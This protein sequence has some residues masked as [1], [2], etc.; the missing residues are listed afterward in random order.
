MNKKS[1]TTSLISSFAFAIVACT[2]TIPNQTSIFKENFQDLDKEYTFNTKELTESYLKRKLEN[3][4]TT[5]VKGDLLLKEIVYARVK[6]PDLYCD[7]MAENTQMLAD[8]NIVSEISERKLLEP[9]F[10][11]FAECDPF[12]GEFRVN[13]YTTNTQREPSIAMDNDGDF[14]VTWQS[15]YQDGSMY[16]IYAQR[17]NKK[18]IQVGSEFRVNTFTTNFQKNA[19]V[20]MDAD[21]DFVITWNS[22]YK[23][24]DQFLGVNAQRYNSS[25]NPVGSEFRV[26]TRTTNSQYFPDVAMDADGD[27]VIAWQSAAQDGSSGDS[28]Y[29]QRYFSDGT[30]NGGEFR[31][32]TNITSVQSH[33]SVA[34]DSGGDIVITWQSYHTGDYAIYGQRYFSNGGANGGEFRINTF[35]TDRQ[36]NSSV[37]MDNQGDF[38]V[39]WQSKQDNGTGTGNLSAYGIYAQRYNRSGGAVGGE[40]QV[41][42][43]TTNMQSHP[44]VAMDSNGDFVVSWGSY[45]QDGGSDGIYAQRYDSNGGTLGSEFRVNTMTYDNQSAQSM[46]MDDSGNFAIIW[47]S[48]LQDPS[49]SMGVYGQRYS[50]NGTPL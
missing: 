15:R 36:V 44:K 23:T 48:R 20:A 11:K 24:G 32:N 49:G 33:P 40:F 46:A 37:S 43:H 16:G 7:L 39:T 2:N 3:W 1:L 30:P 14:V 35:N 47:D 17:Y 29:A 9:A 38:V 21:G 34:M 5:P 50:S 42:T 22:N 25:G 19:R 41:N 45:W 18:G 10:K 31:V 4:L 27:F 13:T 8:I 12:I 28:V 6:H 26:N